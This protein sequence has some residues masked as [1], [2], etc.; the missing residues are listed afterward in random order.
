[1]ASPVGRRGAIMRQR[2]RRRRLRL[3][4]TVGVAVALSLA[5]FYA[6][7]RV[8]A[9][10]FGPSRGSIQ[11]LKKAPVATTGTTEVK[12][13]ASVTKDLFSVPSIASYLAA[14][15][16][17]VTAAVYDDVTGTTSVFRPGD[18]EACA[19]IMKVDILATLLGEAQAQGVV[20]LPADQQVLAQQM[21]EESNDDDAQDLWDFEGG[22][23]AVGHF[24]GQVGLTQTTPDTAGYW[25][26][27]TTTAAD[28][29]QLLRDVAYPNGV[30][31]DASRTYELSLMTNVDPSQTWGISAGVESGATVA[32][33]DGWVTLDNES[34][35]WQV[36][37]IGY[38]NGDG[39]NYVIAVLTTGED[40]EQEG[41]QTIQGLSS[42]IWAQLAPTTRA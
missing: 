30:L 40:T 35:P 36:N 20:S 17:N 23:T 6:V 28:Q 26:L 15:P 12:H 33:K 32:I 24:D 31:T 10:H 11:R 13:A 22:A 37:S 18:A 19:S 39:R 5:G 3:A 41:I 42:L 8:T 1:M 21:I 38:V 25:G 16:Y 9:P 27:S 34:P 14:S 2:R 4:R 29:V 7:S